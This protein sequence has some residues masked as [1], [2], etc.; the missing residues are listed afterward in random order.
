[1]VFGQQ[2]LQRGVDYWA[3]A[4]RPRADEWHGLEASTSDQVLL[5]I[6]YARLR[7]D[8]L[9]REDDGRS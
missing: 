9:S 3:F 7:A 4:I 6:R 1:M 5:Q 2:V 8:W